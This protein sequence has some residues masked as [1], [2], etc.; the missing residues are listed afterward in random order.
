MPIASESP[1]IFEQIAGW[2][3]SLAWGKRSKNQID[4][5]TVCKGC[6][7]FEERWIIKS[8]F[9]KKWAFGKGSLTLGLTIENLRDY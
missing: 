4:L 6:W 3:L 1:I 8:K 5:G 2:S 7:G 9:H